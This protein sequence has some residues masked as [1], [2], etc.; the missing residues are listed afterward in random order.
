M[1]V[2][3]KS[4]VF[5]AIT[6]AISWGVTLG[7][8]AL[9]FAATPVG[10]FVALLAM[11]FGPAIAALVC[12]FAFERGHVR[13]ALGLK[14]TPNWWWLAAYAAGVVFCFGSIA[15]TVFLSANTLSDPAD[16]AIAQTMAVA[17][18]QAAQLQGLP[19]GLILVAQSFLIGPLINAPILTISE[20]LGWRGYLHTLWRPL[21][22]WRASL[23]TGAIWGVWHAPAIYFYGLNYPEHRLIGIPIFIAFCMLL[24]PVMTLIR[25]HGRSVI[26]PGIL[27]GT[28]NAVGGYALLAVAMAPFPWSGIVGIGGLLTLA[29]AVSAIAFSRR[30]LAP[31]APVA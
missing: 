25:D 30:T 28:I 4:A 29:L 22:F 19:L 3:R 20:E 15:L 8:V 1:T 5:L 9:G 26:A 14:W 2:T 6:F 27:H 17:P 10:S 12:A 23:S 13:E 11:M 7:G 16:I 21:G 31:T 24:S 18:E